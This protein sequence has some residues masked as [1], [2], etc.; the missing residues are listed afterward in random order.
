MRKSYV[1]YSVNGSKS[2]YNANNYLPQWQTP[3]LLC[4]PFLLKRFSIPTAEPLN[5]VSHSW[6][7]SVRADVSVCPVSVIKRHLY[8]CC[9]KRLDW[10]HWKPEI[11]LLT[12][13][14]TRS[15]RSRCQHGSWWGLP[16]WIGKWHLLCHIGGHREREWDQ[17]CWCLFLSGHESHGEVPSWHHL[18]PFTLQRPISEH[19]PIRGH[20]LALE[21]GGTVQS[22]QCPGTGTPPSPLPIL[23]AHSSPSKEQEV[24]PCC[25]I[26]S[27]SE[28]LT[29]TQRE[30]Q[31]VRLGI[32]EAP[33]PP[34]PPE[35][36]G[37]AVPLCSQEAQTSL[38]C[39]SGKRTRGVPP[40]WHWSWVD[41]PS[42]QER[43][44]VGD[45]DA[46]VQLAWV[47]MP[48]L[49]HSVCVNLGLSFPMCKVRI[50]TVASS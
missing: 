48:A 11:Y 41:A 45:T 13:L 46:G 22:L 18:N 2:N 25:L 31:R 6:V 19:C 4:L 38:W 40:S 34:G 32:P 50:I 1:Q 16:P 10:G 37:T 39:F 28:V 44:V 29:V 17:A 43:V 12:V 14:G 27:V 47:S 5:V 9:D 33:G 49:L 23:R 21:C 35:R 15:P 8:L 24:Q 42:R 26:A 30:P 7:S 3:I 36:V 20:I